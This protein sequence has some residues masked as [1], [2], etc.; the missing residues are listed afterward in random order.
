MSASKTAVKNYTTIRRI[1]ETARKEFDKRAKA[2]ANAVAL[3]E[4]RGQKYVPNPQYA[5]GALDDKQYLA[6]IESLV[7]R[8]RAAGLLVTDAQYAMLE[9]GE[10][11][12]AD[13]RVRWIAEEVI[14]PAGNGRLYRR[15]QGER[16]RIRQATKQ[17]NGLYIY[18]YL[19]DYPKAALRTDGP[20]VFVLEMEFLQWTPTYFAFERIN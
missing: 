8:K 15:R 6:W 2:E 14:Q 17:P 13:D 20:E 11:L 18:T 9:R 5:P 12:R 19:P 16:G 7:Q 1:R 4:E 3:A 10:I